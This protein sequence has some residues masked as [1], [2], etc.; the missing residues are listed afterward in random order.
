MWKW[1]DHGQSPWTG[2]IAWLWW[3]FKAMRLVYG[4]YHYIKHSC[5]NKLCWNIALEPECVLRGYIISTDTCVIHIILRVNG[6]IYNWAA[7]KMWAAKHGCSEVVV[8]CISEANT[9]YGKFQAYVE[10]AWKQMWWSQWSMTQLVT[11]E[12]TQE[13]CPE[14]L[15]NRQISQWIGVSIST[16]SLWIRRYVKTGSTSDK[17]WWSCP[18]CTTQEEDQGL[19]LESTLVYCSQYCSRIV[20]NDFLPILQAI[21]WYC[22]YDISKGNNL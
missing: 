3:H 22:I 4:A 6:A 10:L 20:N 7:A 2:W 16:I 21:L 13:K 12:A 9:V 15:C 1:V 14:G 17:C 19:P 5:L 18:R 11:M 8:W